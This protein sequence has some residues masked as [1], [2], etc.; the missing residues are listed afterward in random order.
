MLLQMILYTS[1][2]TKAIPTTLKPLKS[3]N[4]KTI[5]TTVSNEANC[6]IPVLESNLPK[7]QEAHLLGAF[8]S[9]SELGAN[10]SRLKSSPARSP[11]LPGPPPRPPP[12]PRGSRG[13]GSGIDERQPPLS[14]NPPAPVSPLLS[15]EREG[16]Q[17]S[18]ERLRNSPLPPW[19]ASGAGPAPLPC[20]SP[21]GG[22][23]PRAPRS[24]RRRKH[25]EP[26]RDPS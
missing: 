15:P 17:E 9:S 12:P 25:E 19:S 13:G 23:T 7:V 18:S 1:H 14:P 26:E 5:P 16:E 6:L 11:A 10:F 3:H 24:E 21:G 2:N 8:P 4:T 20:W 22:L